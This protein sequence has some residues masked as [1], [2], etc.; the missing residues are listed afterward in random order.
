MNVSVGQHRR[1]ILAAR[2]VMG[3]AAAFVLL[4]MHQTVGTTPH[5]GAGASPPKSQV[6]TKATKTAHALVSHVDPAHA[7]A[8][9]GM[10]GQCGLAIICIAAIIGLGALLLLVGKAHR[11]ILWVAPHPL[12]VVIGSVALPH[13]PLNPLQRTCVL[14]C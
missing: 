1:R 11:A 7:P 5:E 3:L 13:H 14:R 6:A 8:G 2:M 4:A 9:D 10:V 12:R